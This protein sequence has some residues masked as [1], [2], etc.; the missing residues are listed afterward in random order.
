M[1]TQINVISF[2]LGVESMP[3][4]DAYLNAI[5]SNDISLELGVGNCERGVVL[6]S[7]PH[8]TPQ[9]PF[10]KLPGFSQL[11]TGNW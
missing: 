2:K 8:C 11:V 3:M 4:N 9:S 5:V 6:V 1:V 10:P 7:A